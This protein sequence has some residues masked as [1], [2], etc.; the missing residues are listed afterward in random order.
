[1][2]RLSRALAAALLVASP[3]SL[4]AQSRANEHV[5]FVVLGHLRGDRNGELLVNLPEVV[6]AVRSENPDL[7]FLC[8]DLIW[9]DIDGAGPTDPAAIR[10]DWE[11]LDSALIGVGAPIHRVPGNH[12]VCDVVTRDIWRERY[13]VLPRSVEFGN[14][15][16]ILL[17]S[18]WSPADGDARKHPQDKIRGVP[19]DSAQIAFLRAE[20]EHPGAAEHVFAFMHHMLWWED[21]AAWWRDVAPVLDGH[22]VAAVFAGDYGPLKFSHLERGGVHYYQTS[23]ENRVGT[24]ILRRSE[25]S[26]L[27]SAQLDTYLVVDVDGADVRTSVR[28]VGAASTGKFSPAHYREIYEYDKDTYGRKLSKRWKTP[29]LLI[30]GLLQVSAVAFAAGALSVITFALVRR[31]L[32]RK[33]A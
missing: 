13:G 5:R 3:L 12:D 2:S 14:A 28:T 18:A 7:V 6:A 8:G 24:E 9:G 16:F 19:L 10:A 22:A 17:N 30:A 1:V 20:L 15:R 4:A 31:W 32:A 33:R 25:A 29:G 23:I 11:R 26:R 21:D 27:L